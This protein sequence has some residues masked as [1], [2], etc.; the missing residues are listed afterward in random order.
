MIYLFYGTDF[1]KARIKANETVDVLRK[2]KPDAS[3][4][5]I[6]DEDRDNSR[7]PELIGGQGLFENKYI[8]FMDRV[9][10]NEEAL[11]LILKN[12]KDIGASQNIFIF[13][14]AKVNKPIVEKVKKSG[15]K[16][17]EFTGEKSSGRKFLMENDKSFSLGEFNV[18]SLTD[19]FGRKDKKNLWVLY[20]ETKDRNI[21]TEEIHGIIFW[22][23][24]CMFLARDSKT[25]EEAGLKPFPYQKA[26]GF[27]KNFKEGE[28]EK[29]SSELVR[30]YHESRMKSRSFETEFEK[31]ILNL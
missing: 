25:A 27:L 6:T 4:I 8:V 18:F 5:K 7:L 20:Q 19:A 12:L 13:L 9:F 17:Q 22:Q 2:K 28:L 29:I 11:E 30:I 23:L 1:E 14:E 26:K 31:F 16:L 3:F 10:G 21:P 15:G 24:K